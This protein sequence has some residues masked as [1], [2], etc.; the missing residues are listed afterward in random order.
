MSSLICRLVSTIPA[1]MPLNH[2]LEAHRE[3]CLRCQADVAR[4]SGMS[5][6]LSSIGDET[7]TAPD[8]LATTV[9]SRLPAQDGSDPRRPM[10]VRIAVRYSVAAA[11]ALATAAALIA[12]ALAKRED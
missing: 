3:T 12:R 4:S 5:R 8:G 6:D 10:V 1:D 11:I 9:M 2:V 7:L